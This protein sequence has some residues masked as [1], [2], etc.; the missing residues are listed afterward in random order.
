MIE[1]NWFQNIRF[2]VLIE[3]YR[4]H[5]HGILLHIPTSGLSLKSFLFSKMEPSSL[6]Y[7]TSS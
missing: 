1:T 5:C 2:K 7:E 3:K 6:N 4:I